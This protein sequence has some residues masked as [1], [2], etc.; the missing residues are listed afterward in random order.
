[1]V[2]NTLTTRV[3]EDSMASNIFEID[4]M[5]CGGCEK[6]VTRCIEGIA[7]VNAVRVD[8]HERKAVVTWSDTASEQDRLT[9]RALI[10]DRVGA[11]G[12]ECRPLD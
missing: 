3:K 9:S 11:A 6:S 2:S 1:M 8:R 12:F 10:C 7:H 5:T 4:G